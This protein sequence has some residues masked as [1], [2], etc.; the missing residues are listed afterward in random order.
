MRNYFAT[1]VDAQ[2]LR[3]EPITWL[4]API[5]YQWNGYVSM[6]SAAIVMCLG[7]GRVAAV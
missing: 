3:V 2:Y 6:R 5:V 4:P 7:K 1:P